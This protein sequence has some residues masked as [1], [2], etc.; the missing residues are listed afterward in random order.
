SQ[1]YSP[2]EWILLHAAEQ[3]PGIWVSR[4]GR[5]EKDATV[6]G[7]VLVGAGAIIRS[8]ARVGPAVFLGDGSVVERGCT[9]EDVLI[10]ED[11]IVGESVTARNAVLTPTGILSA[12][13]NGQFLPIEDP[14]ILTRRNARD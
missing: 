5:I 14:L 3:S 6:I 8:G 2:S 7:P 10:E 4:G 9:L 1:V 12:E 11:T 13:E